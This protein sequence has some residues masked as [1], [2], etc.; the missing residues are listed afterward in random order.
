MMKSVDRGANLFVY[1]KLSKL[2]IYMY[3]Y[4]TSRIV[5]AAFS[6][7]G[8]GAQATIYSLQVSSGTKRFTARIAQSRSNT[9][10]TVQRQKAER[11]EKS[12]FIVLWSYV[13]KVFRFGV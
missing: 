5:L 2:I 10:N 4:C 3:I 8:C 1:H 6:V 9:P 7:Q 11:E 13:I 12:V